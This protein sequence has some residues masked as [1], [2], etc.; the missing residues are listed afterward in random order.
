M[1]ERV[2]RRRDYEPVICPKCGHSQD[3]GLKESHEGK[4]LG[5]GWRNEAIA[6]RGV[7][8]HE[9]SAHDAETKAEAHKIK[10]AR[11]NAG[12]APEDPT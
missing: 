3:G 10:R 11:K 4:C 7:A 5:C 9:G 2:H 12:K 1:T 6:R 8:P